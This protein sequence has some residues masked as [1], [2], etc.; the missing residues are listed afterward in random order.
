[1]PIQI[2]TTVTIRACSFKEGC[3]DGLVFTNTYMINERK[4]ESLPVVFLTTSDE[5][6]Y[7]DSL[8]IYCVGTNGIKLTSQNPVANYNRDWTRWGNIEYYDESRN[9]YIN[10]QTGISISGNASRGYPQKSFK[11]KGR[12][13][14]G[15]KRFDYPLFPV[16][17]SLRYKSFLLRAGGQYYN[18]VQLV[19]DALIQS[20]AQV[21]GIDF[22]AALPAVVYLNGE[23]WGI[24]N[25]RERKNKD[26]IYSHYGLSERDVNIVE[27]AWKATS[28]AGN[29]NQWKEFESYILSADLT[30]KSV[31]S[32]VCDM[33][34]I[35]NFLYY[36]SV[37]IMAKNNDWPNNNQQIFKS[38]SE[39]GKWKWMLQDLDKCFEDN[40]KRNI[41]K[42][43][44]ESE[45]TFLHVSNNP[46]ARTARTKKK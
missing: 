31:Y 2:D 16:R 14:F 7:D 19:H 23:Y 15:T 9:L 41:L 39:D 5:N 37:Q 25:L 40:K 20:V 35:D 32:R 22:Q 43:M 46:H 13:R 4:P 44:Q 10:Q 21:T 36:M 27:Y 45:S 38:L 28:S 18:T 26:Y 17:E 12:S 11:L 34:D 29:L 3:F 6:L 24:Y 33:M 1:M 42:E 30:D 8:G